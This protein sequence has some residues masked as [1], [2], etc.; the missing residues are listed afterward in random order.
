VS[1]PFHKCLF[2]PTF[3]P[4]SRASTPLPFRWVFEWLVCG[5]TGDRF[6]VADEKVEGVE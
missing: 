5:V 1:E 6:C 4:L 2:R 3:S